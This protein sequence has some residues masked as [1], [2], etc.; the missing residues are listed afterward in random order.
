M[1]TQ[2]PSGLD[3]TGVLAIWSDAVPEHETE[4]NDWYSSQHLP[5]RVGVPGFR[6]GRRYVKDTPGELRY[7]TLYECATIEV[8]ASA[9]YLERLNNPTDWTRRAMPFFRNGSRA[10]MVVA[11]SAGA[12]IGGLAATI[13]FTPAPD[14]AADLQ[15]WIAAAGRALR[16]THP[17][18]TGWHLCQSDDAVTRAKAG[19]EEAR[20]SRRPTAPA[21]PA[22]ATAPA[23][24]HTPR[25]L[26]MAEAT[27]RAPLD[28]AAELLA[29]DTGLGG[30]GAT[31]LTAFHVYRLMLALTHADPE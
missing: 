23:V 22:P 28:A 6:R 18:L 14:R 11:S 13:Q 21:P 17:A 9:P 27:D 16:E 29:G 31:D 26:L 30:Q 4:F 5:E 8:L 25:W 10:A 7:F 3:G 19:T 2:Q 1:P 12:G 20:A 15:S 24:P